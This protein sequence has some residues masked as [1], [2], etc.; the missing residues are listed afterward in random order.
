MATKNKETVLTIE[1]LEASEVNEVKIGGK[2]VALNVREGSQ[3]KDREG[4]PM[5]DEATHE[6]LMWGDSYYVDFAFQGGETSIKVN[7]DVYDSLEIGKRFQF[8]G[9]AFMKTPYGDGKPYLS[10][11]SIRFDFLF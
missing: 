10:I 3:R 6:P 2:V 7:K 11:E 5:F 9:R 8:V 1:M 4:N